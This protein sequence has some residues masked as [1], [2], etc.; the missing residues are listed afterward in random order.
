MKRVIFL[1][2]FLMLLSCSSTG[3]REGLVLEY[4]NV[5]SDS[6]LWA[7]ETV[8]YENSRFIFGDNSLVID[9]AKGATV[10][11]KKE[12]EGDCVIEYD[13]TIVSQGGVNDRVSDM[14]CFWMFS[15]PHQKDKGLAFSDN[16]RGGKF[17]HYNTLQGYYVGLGG[18]KNTR[19][20][21][22]RYNGNYERDL[23][24]EHDLTAAEFLIIPNQKYHV[25]LVA[26]GSK[27]QY[28]RDDQLIFDYTDPAP[29][30][31]GFF[32]F[33]TVNNHMIIQDFKSY[34]LK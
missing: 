13:I 2:S 5:L 25:T 32:A 27:V 14:N 28:W 16:S 6:S 30:T 7:V 34:A 21:F 31:N 10:W 4:T 1:S 24:P 3:V 26:R 22:R 12:L 23:L 20:R 11:F 29:Y 17:T 33:R 18:H 19:T 15:D 8:T 9:A